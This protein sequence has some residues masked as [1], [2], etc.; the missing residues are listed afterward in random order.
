VAFVHLSVILALPQAPPSDLI[1]EVA[2]K[3][4]EF[5]AARDQY[6]YRQTV[7]F[8]E[9]DPRGAEVGRYRE[10]R[11][12]IFN[13]QK[14]RTEVLLE[15]PLQALKNLRLTEEDFRDIREVNP[16]VLTRESLP[17]YTVRYMGREPMD[18]V[19]CYVYL[20]RPRQ[21]LDE[22]RLF[23]GRIW[24][25][26]AD[27]QIIRAEGR[28]VPQIYREKGENLFPHFTTLYRAIDGRYWF[29]V[30]TFADDTLPF[31]SGPQRV[32]ITVQYDD[33]KRFSAETTFQP[34]NPG[35]SESRPP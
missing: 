24:I 22:L 34:L 16:F 27:R 11:D 7:L 19:D 2:M 4:A 28:P 35:A 25:S 21:I 13:P 33:Y 30:R 12:I 31:R 1:R 14:E 17:H 20:L 15:R 23:E 29:P 18:E 3:A 26:A 8:Q 10:V 9:L 6:T 5:Q 32:R